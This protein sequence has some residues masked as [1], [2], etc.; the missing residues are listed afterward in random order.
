MDN[1][2][3]DLEFWKN[4]SVALLALASIQGV[5]YWTLYKLVKTRMSFKE[6]LKLEKNVDFIAVLK[7]HGSRSIKLPEAS[8]S[9]QQE[10]IW[11]ARRKMYRR[12]ISKGIDIMHSGHPDFPERL[13]S[14]SDAPE[15]LFYQGN[16][17]LLRKP[18]LAIVGTRKPTQD[19]DSPGTSKITCSSCNGQGQVRISISIF[20]P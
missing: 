15:W 4:E 17:D 6:A 2:A 7:E 9:Q 19:G 20:L 1:T 10:I 18:S 12:L 14:I 8:W 5:G 13:Q 3:T 16:L 11:D